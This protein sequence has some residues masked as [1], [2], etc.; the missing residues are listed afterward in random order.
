MPTLP[1]VLTDGALQPED[2][3]VDAMEVPAE[4]QQHPKD[5]GNSA[6]GSKEVGNRVIHKYSSSGLIA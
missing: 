5:N 6:N 4:V 2:G 1:S 3:Q